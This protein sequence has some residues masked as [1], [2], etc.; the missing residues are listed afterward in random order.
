M[1]PQVNRIYHVEKPL[2]QD[3]L[4]FES[5]T[6][7]N[8]LVLDGVI[9]VTEHREL[10]YHEM[11][12]FLPLASHPNPER[13]LDEAVIRVSRLYLLHMSELL[14][15]SNVAIHI[16]DSFKFLREHKGIYDV[17]VTDLLEV[18]NYGL[19]RWRATTMRG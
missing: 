18:S 6:Y 15:D 4:V 7:V 2:Y 17:I 8:V 1:T 10:S 11:I 12:S 14:E 3:V 9:R 16:G 19:S 13:V 5:A